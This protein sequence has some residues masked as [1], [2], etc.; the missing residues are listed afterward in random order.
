MVSLQSVCSQHPKNASEGGRLTTRRE[1]ILVLLEN[2]LDVIQ[3]LQD[4]GISDGDVIWRMC[5]A[6][7]H[8][9]YRE[10]E[11]LRKVL[12]DS[13][14]FIYWHLAETYFRASVLPAKVCPHCWDTL[15]KRTEWWPPHLGPDFHR[16]GGK[17]VSLVLRP[18]RRISQ[19]IRPE[20]VEQA[21]AW[22]DDH[23]R[24]EPFV[25]D[26]VLAVMARQDAA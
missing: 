1:K 21:V 26:D 22:I 16:H 19:A 5:R 12:R 17:T 20:C 2:Y 3:G 10:L 13:E 25:P 4:S 8:P 15:K 7:S 9:S 18:V 14:P 23:F 24:G 6:Y 11:R